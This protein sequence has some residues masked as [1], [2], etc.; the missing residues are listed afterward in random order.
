MSTVAV[1][2]GDNVNRD[3]T[4]D[5]FV[6]NN[7]F[8]TLVGGTVSI[9][10]NG[11]EFPGIHAIHTFGENINILYN[12]VHEVTYGKDHEAIYMKAIN[13]T[14]AHNVV[15]NG[16]SNGGGDGD[17]TIKGGANVN[18]LVFGNRVTGDQ[19]GTGI[20][21]HGEVRIE[22]N[23][24]NKRASSGRH[25]INIYAYGMP[26][27]VLDNHIETEL[28]GSAIRIDGAVGGEIRDNLI[29]NHTAANL[30]IR[31]RQSSE[32][33]QSGNIECIGSQCND[34]TP[35]IRTCQNQGYICCDTCL[36]GAQGQLDASCASGK[37]CCDPPF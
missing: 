8:D 6:T 30:T 35:P 20:T 18:N 14:I 15:H 17:I 1:K 12:T 4:R 5:I 31:L 36:S 27:T 23:Y 11:N 21:I 34:L 33:V 3:T 25:G 19:A 22:N 37:R 2:I 29:I 10:P 24:V 7:Y 13:S 16:G 32:I 26:V 28:G 9:D